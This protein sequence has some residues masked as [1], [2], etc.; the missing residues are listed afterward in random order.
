M[1]KRLTRKQKIIRRN[2]FL[3]LCA[4]VLIGVISLLG[5]GVGKLITLIDTNEPQNNSSVQSEPEYVEPYVVSSATVVNTGDILIHGPVLKGAYNSDTKEYD[6][7]ALYRYTKDYFDKA[8]LVIANLE[9]TLGGSES[10]SYR[11]YPSF[12]T[13]DS[14]IDDLKEAGIDM[15]LTSNNH[16][17][18]TGL[19]GIKRTARVLKEKN[20]DFIGTRETEDEPIYTVKDVKGI[21]I[22]MACYTYENKNEDT[23]RK[24]INGA[25]INTQA[26][27][28]LNSFSYNH[29]EDFYTEAGSVIAD[30]KQKGA[31]AIVFYMHWGEEYQLTQN[32]WQKNIAQKLCDLGVDIIVGGHPHVIQPI[33]MLSSSDGLHKT[34]CLYSMGNSVSNQR[35]SALYKSCPTG[36]TEDGMLF[37]YTFDKYS[38]G[39]VMLSS[40]DIVPAW[41]RK[42]G[43]SNSAQYSLFPL[44]NAD[45]Y[46]QYSLTDKT[47]AGSYERTKNIVGQGLTA[48]QQELG[49]K[50]RF[51]E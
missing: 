31:E 4:V 36:H 10:G 8:D 34:I 37:Y 44:E 7:S 26:N 30:M 23:S 46:N 39:K 14:L 33:E 5:L 28:L 25:I 35:L 11:G 16:C 32:T 29:I 50:V 42:T 19:F 41:V 9:V 20:V 3:G 43:S 21:K 1:K 27:N 22:G 45:S 49:C 51:A 15:L 24:S 18:D 17:Y 38:D 6:F 40:V 47:A 12:N 2:L 13:P 48:C